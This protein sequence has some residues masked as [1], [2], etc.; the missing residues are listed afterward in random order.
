MALR[1]GIS[2]AIAHAGGSTLARR[3]MAEMAKA[4]ARDGRAPV[5]PLLYPY[6]VESLL[7]AIAEYDPEYSPALAERWRT[8][9]N[10]TVGF[11]AEQY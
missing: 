2:S 6:W 9:M 3:T 7:K 10:R 11:F 5:P 4:H 8:A 1:R